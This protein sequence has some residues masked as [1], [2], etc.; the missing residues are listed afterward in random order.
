MLTNREEYIKNTFFK[1][2]T[3]SEAIEIV[4]KIS[5]IGEKIGFVGANVSKNKEKLEKRKHKYDVWISR[6]VKKNKEILDKVLEIRLIIDWAVETSA[7]IF[8]YSFEEAIKSQINW[9]HDMMVKYR[10]EK[11]N[12]PD[13]DDN[14][15]VFRFS[16]KEHFLYL[17]KEKDLKYEGSMM[18]HCVGGKNYKSK[19]KNK[20]SIIL[21]IRD[22]KN[23]PHAT[24][25][26]DVSSRTIVQKFGKSNQPPVY[27]YLKMY[28]EYA[29]FASDYKNLENKE[30]VKFLN[31]DF[32]KKET[33]YNKK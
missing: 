23:I 14:R 32:N 6:E 16:D 24:I 25:E 27:K 15:V 28:A 4:K 29:L 22:G 20:Q 12:I 17:L 18:G 10:I 9:H 26:V 33:I 21:S 1:N 11:I 13:I 30:I 31:L 19:I 2:L 7:D 5:S 8:K 3:N